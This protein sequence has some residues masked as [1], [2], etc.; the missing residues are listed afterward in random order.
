VRHNAGDHTKRAIEADAYKHSRRDNK[1]R[2]EPDQF[3]QHQV[4]LARSQL[5]QLFNAT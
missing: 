2:Q 5:F 4:C 3:P 1:D